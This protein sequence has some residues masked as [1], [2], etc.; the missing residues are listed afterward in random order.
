VYKEKRG[1]FRWRLKADSVVIASSDCFYSKAGADKAIDLL[2]ANAP[3]ATVAP[4]TVRPKISHPRSD[5]A[6]KFWK[7][8]TD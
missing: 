7:S 3:I 2:K 6:R 1:Y 4:W 8:K 5:N